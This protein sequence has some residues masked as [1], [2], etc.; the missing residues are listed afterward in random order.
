MLREAAMST[1]DI[2][3]QAEEASMLAVS[4]RA[5]TDVIRDLVKRDKYPEHELRAREARLPV[6]DAMVKTMRAIASNPDAVRA[7]IVAGR[8]E[9][10]GAH[11]EHR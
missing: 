5:R 11:D 9:T 2:D 4:F 8:R 10:D 7:A 3:M 1:P 6:I